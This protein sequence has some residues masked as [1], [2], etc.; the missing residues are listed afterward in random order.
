LGTGGS[1]TGVD[2]LDLVN[3]S[4]TGNGIMPAI[5]NRELDGYIKFLQSNLTNGDT[6][7][8]VMGISN[9]IY[10]DSNDVNVE[11]TVVVL[12]GVQATSLSNTGLE[13]GSVW[14]M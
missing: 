11:D 5:S 6:V 8:F 14:M 9:Y 1:T 10:Q 3:T 12:L 2:R 13:A 4:F 7:G